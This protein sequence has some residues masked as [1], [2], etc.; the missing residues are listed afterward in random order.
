[1]ECVALARYRRQDLGAKNLAATLGRGGASARG[2]GVGVLRYLAMLV[3]SAVVLLGST[4]VIVL[5]AKDIAAALIMPAVVVGVL[6]IAIITSL[7]E[8]TIG[9]RGVLKG[10]AGVALG[11]V[12]GAATINS[13]FTLGTVALLSPVVV[14]DMRIIWSSIFFTI[15]VFLLIFYFLHTKQSLSRREGVLLVGAFFAFIG[16]QIWLI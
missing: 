14:T 8:L 11:D 6:I 1:M 7:P 5:I 16:M 2:I 13:T 3:V 12:F 10:R 9:V 15:F 4:Y